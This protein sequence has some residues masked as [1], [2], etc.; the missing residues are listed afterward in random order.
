MAAPG[1]MVETDNE[2]YFRIIYRF[3]KQVLLTVPNWADGVRDECVQRALAADLMPVGEVLLGEAE[4]D[5]PDVGE[6]QIQLPE[7]IQFDTSK[8]PKLNTNEFMKGF[9]GGGVVSVNMCKVT[10]EVML[11]G[12]MG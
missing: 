1:V 6:V 8:A 7:G 4:D 9:L 12:G 5:E 11:M 2:T 10:A 3:P